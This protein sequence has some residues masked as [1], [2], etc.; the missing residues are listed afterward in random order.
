MRYAKDCPPPKLLV[1]R[2]TAEAMIEHAGYVSEWISEGKLLPVNGDDPTPLYD[3]EDIK[4]L[5]LGMK[6]ANRRF[7][8]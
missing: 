1:R 7:K 8:G 4:T 3:V 2:A 6:N 5:V